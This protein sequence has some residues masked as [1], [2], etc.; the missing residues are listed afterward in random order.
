MILSR[1][2]LLSVTVRNCFMQLSRTELDLPM[3][4]A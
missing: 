4:M 1:P 2:V 3:I